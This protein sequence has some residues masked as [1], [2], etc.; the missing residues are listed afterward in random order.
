M[1]VKTEQQTNQREQDSCPECRSKSIILDN[2]TG[3]RICGG[4]GLVMADNIMSEGP[5][6]RAFSQD[7]RESRSRVGMPLSFS[8][9]D[10]GLSTMIGQVGKD[11]FGRTIPSKT[12]FQMLRLKKWHIRSSYQ[13]SVDRNLSHAM[14][15]LSRLTDKLHIPKP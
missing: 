13:S 8:V 6:W 9:H 12:M 4:C 1:I 14:T 7:E 10:K 15:E 2:D 5:E 11:A 3:E